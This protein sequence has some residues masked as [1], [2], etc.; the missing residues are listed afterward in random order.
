[1]RNLIPF[2][3]IAALIVAASAYIAF[4]R[5]EPLPEG[6]IQANGR[7]EA[8][9]VSVTTK[10]AGRVV[11]LVVNEGDRVA[12]GDVVARLDDTQARA[13]LEQAE[14]RVASLT[15][16]IA[17]AREELDLLVRQAPL[18]VEA[19]G[20]EVARLEAAVAKALAIEAQRRRD[21]ARYSEIAEENAATRR[22]LDQAETALAV[23]ESERMLEEASLRRARASLALARLVDLRI[24]AKEASIDSL[25]AQKTEAEAAALEARSTL[26][27]L[28]LRAPADGVITVRLAN[29][30][31]TL[32]AG[33]PVFDLVDLDAL[34]LKVYIPEIEIGKVRLGLPARVHIDALPDRPIPATV[35][36]IAS[37][38]EFTPKEV[39][40]PEERA[41]LVFAAKLYLDENPDHA[42]G[43][44]LPADAVIKW[45]D[46]AEWAPP[47]W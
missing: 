22:E 20:A 18:E 4:G 23:A 5:R 24:S 42:V 3:A 43:P 27:D 16:Q 45:Q 41:K 28:V 21:V 9:H 2:I 39:Q 37:E 32:G 7:I 31:E 44:G 15:Q 13:R 10:F 14:A 11:E 26:E 30:G 25:E 35:R 19:A 12:Q 34:Y 40:T 36:F 1:M 29:L 8:D 46:D 47:R 38:A 17:A 6:L 33:A